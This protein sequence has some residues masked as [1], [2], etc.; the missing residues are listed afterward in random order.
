MRL[1]LPSRHQ[2]P[3]VGLVNPKYDEWMSRLPEEL[4]DVPLSNL[5]I[6]GSHD[7]MTYCLDMSS[8]VVRSKGAFIRLLDRLFSCLTRPAIQRWA[9]TQH[10][11]IVDQLQMGIRYFDLRIARKPHD[12]SNF[13][14]FTHVIYTHVTVLETLASVVSWLET[15]P[16]E[17]LILACS[18]FEGMSAKVHVS[19]IMSLKKLFGSMLCP[20]KEAVPTLRCLWSNRWQVLLSYEDQSAVRYPELWPAIP[21]WWADQLTARGVIKYLDWQKDMGRPDCLFV[22]GLNLTADT[23]FMA[24]EPNRSLWSLTQENWDQLRV[25]LQDQTSG[26]S[27]HSLNIIAGDFVGPIAFCPLVIALNQELLLNSQHRKMP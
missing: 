9:T 6:P 10:K 1:Q 23:C 18:H 15:H 22:S 16:R 25:W 7:A 21:Y 14:Y 27:P 26:G 17:V 19:F 24:L 2:P 4:W 8:P 11:S 3:P 13:L 20:R 12:L 5:A